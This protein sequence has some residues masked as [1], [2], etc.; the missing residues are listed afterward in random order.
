[1]E[2]ARDEST[3]TLLQNGEVLI[4]GGEKG[5]GDPLS[6]AELFNPATG[7]FTPDWVSADWPLFCHG[8][9]AGRWQRAR[10]GRQGSE[11]RQP[12]QR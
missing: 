1:M 4:A 11:F 10:G 3:A 6:E 5:V 7:T 9:T 2:T 8:N 12:C